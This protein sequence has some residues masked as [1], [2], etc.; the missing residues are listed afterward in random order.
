[1]SVPNYTLSNGFKMPFVG[2]GTY[3]VIT[4]VLD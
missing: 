4:D 3:K 2:L 1:M